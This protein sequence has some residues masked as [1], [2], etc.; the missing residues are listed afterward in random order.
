MRPRSSLQD[1]SRTG[2]KRLL[3]LREF[4]QRRLPRPDDREPSTSYVV[5][6][7]ANFWWQFSRALYFSIAMG[8]QD[9][10]GTIQST[11]MTFSAPIDALTFA[12]RHAKPNTHGQ[13]SPPWIPR[14][15]PDWRLVG[16][17][18]K[19][20]AGI[21]LMPSSSA[22]TALGYVT[23]VFDHL[24]PM[25]NFFAH[26]GP[27]TGRSARRIGLAYS[28][29]GFDRPDELLLRPAPARPQPLLLDWID[30]VAI[31][32]DLARG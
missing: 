12:I 15:E 4:A 31:V 6:E 16:I 7:L 8:A 25:R 20:Y 24:P 14:D 1:L 5:I 18:K 26:K 23:S 28:R 30:D 19:L 32:V 10:Y 3:R 11:A 13:R 22:Y 29:S 2:G 21:G 9:Q 27:D 17:T